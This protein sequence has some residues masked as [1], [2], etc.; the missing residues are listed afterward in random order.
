MTWEFS[1]LSP[2]GIQQVPDE[3][4]GRAPSV[5]A[6][7]CASNGAEVPWNEGGHGMAGI[8]RRCVTSA[9]VRPAGSTQARQGPST[10]S[11]GNPMCDSNTRFR[12]PPVSLRSSF[13]RCAASSRCSQGSAKQSKLSP[14]LI[15]VFCTRSTG[16]LCATALQVLMAK[17]LGCCKWKDATEPGCQAS[18]CIYYSTYCS[19]MELGLSRTD[20]RD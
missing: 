15:C 13:G 1:V 14:T 6:V 5:R 8:H 19:S 20:S 18:S 12:S 11:S 3:Q 16:E 2:S 7:R 4:A 17:V 10:P 9:W